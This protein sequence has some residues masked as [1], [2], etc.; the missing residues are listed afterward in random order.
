M[1]LH[2]EDVDQSR[3]IFPLIYGD[4]SVGKT[5]LIGSGGRDLKTLI[6]R[7]PTDHVDA[8]VG[9]GVKQTVVKDWEEIWE[10]LEY[11]R[12]EGHEWDWV[13][14]DSISLMQDFGLDDVYTN[15]LDK[16]GPE[17]S[18]ARKAREQFGPD[19]GE[20]RVN[21]WRLEQWI[22]HTIGAAQFNFG[23]TAHPFWYEPKDEDIEPYLMPWIQGRNMPNKICGM[24]NMVGYYQLREREVKGEKKMTRVLHTTKTPTWYAKSQ[25]KLPD[26]SGVFGDTG[27][28]ANPTIPKILEAINAGRTAPPKARTRKPAGRRPAVRPSA[29]KGS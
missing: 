12:H 9:S 11:L 20:Y 5:T 10:V 6:V 8:I 25:F 16:K 13:W 14:L 15:T 21:M 28:I 24:M 3:K 1:T 23:V 2:I 18:L 7:P 17:G 19:Q 26:G 22:R 27:S 4:P 29:R